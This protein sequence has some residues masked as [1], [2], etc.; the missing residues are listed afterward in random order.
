MHV[1]WIYKIWETI[2]YENIK[3]KK[4]DDN[5]SVIIII[6]IILVILIGEINN[7]DIDYASQT[8]LILSLTT[9][10][11]FRWP[12]IQRFCWYGVLL[13]NLIL[14]TSFDYVPFFLNKRII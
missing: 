3:L 8:N 14:C 12:D 4:T 13:I 9:F 1:I 11:S 5:K 7:N 2:I 10:I 6:N